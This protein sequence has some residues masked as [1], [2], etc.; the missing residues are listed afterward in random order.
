MSE[1]EIS[2]EL[3]ELGTISRSARMVYVDVCHWIANR[4]S[5]IGGLGLLDISSE[6]ESG[7]MQDFSP[8]AREMLAL[9]CVIGGDPKEVFESL[10]ELL[11]PAT[12]MIGFQTRNGKRHIVVK[13]WGTFVRI[14]EEE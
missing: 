11:L 3:F 9:L 1:I 7:W 4:G 6:V 8:G 14:S 12:D 2:S 13:N 5:V 10:P